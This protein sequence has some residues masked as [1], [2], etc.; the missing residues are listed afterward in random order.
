[1]VIDEDKFVCSRCG[2]EKEKLQAILANKLKATAK[3]HDLRF[4]TL[5]G[6]DLQIFNG[7]K[8]LFDGQD[9]GIFRPIDR[10]YGENDGLLW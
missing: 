6:G 5:G 3:D 8:L 4:N 7:N 10:S 2:T 1:M 9:P